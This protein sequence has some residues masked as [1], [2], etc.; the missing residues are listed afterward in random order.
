MNEDTTNQM[1][2]Y[3]VSMDGLKMIQRKRWLLLRKSQMELEFE[4]IKKELEE[5]EGLQ[6]Q[7]EKA[8]KVYD[9]KMSKLA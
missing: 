7:L 8:K 1:F 2:D 6:Q 4:V 3:H 9:E 5:I